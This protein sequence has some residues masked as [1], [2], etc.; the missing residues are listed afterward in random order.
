MKAYYVESANLRQNIETLKLKAADSVFWAVLKGNGYGVGLLPMANLCREG[1]IDHFAVTEIHEVRLLRENG[2]EKEPI[3]MLTPT[4]DADEVRALLALNAIFTVSSQEDAAILNGIAA[5]SGVIADAHIKIDTG[6]GRYGF[7]TDELDKFLPVYNYMDNI[8]VSGI[9][10]HLSCAFC[11]KKMVKKQLEEF[12]GVLTQ[13][14]AAG[15]EPGCA[16]VLNSAGL[17]RFPESR[18]G[19]VRIGSALLGRV[20]IKGR[21]GLKRVGC[22][23]ANISEIRWLRKGDTCGYGAGFRAK[24]PTRIAVIPVGYYHGFGTEMGNDLFRVRDQLRRCVSALLGILHPRRYFVRVGTQKCRVLGH[25]GMLHTVI[26][27]SK[28]NCS[29]GDSVQLDINPLLLKGME[30]KY[31]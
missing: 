22:C 15:F 8:A 17:L 20:A 27:V 29:L 14:I 30:I 28:V 10:T 16:H 3:L 12:N 21:S 23:R 11:S 1:G 4:A 9:Y 2:F 18:M 24:K 25:I 7:H 6:M 31:I 13:I 26:D 5:Q 19:G